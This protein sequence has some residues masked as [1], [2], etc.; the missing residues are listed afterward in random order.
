MMK[1]LLYDY[2]FDPRYLNNVIFYKCCSDDTIDMLKL[3][4]DHCSINLS[5]SNNKLLYTIMLHVLENT[6]SKMVR[7]LL[8]NGFDPNTNNGECLI[9]VSDYGY[10]DL[11]KLFIEFGADVTHQD[12]QALYMAILNLNM[13]TVIVLLQN[14]ADMTAI[15]R[16]FEAHQ[17]NK[18]KK[19]INL[20]IENDIDA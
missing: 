6:N 16:R 12:N 19:F 10:V 4:L 7:M 9:T 15:N 1:I 5:D 18:K 2:D 13:D 20:L 17:N 3:L 8:E 11:V 14:G